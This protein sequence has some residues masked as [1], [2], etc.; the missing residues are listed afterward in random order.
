MPLLPCATLPHRAAEDFQS[1]GARERC[2]CSGAVLLPVLV[3]LAQASM[4]TSGEARLSPAG[5]VLS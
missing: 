4:P 3:L 5:A 1:S 2:A